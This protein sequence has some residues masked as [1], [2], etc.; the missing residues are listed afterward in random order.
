MPLGSRR[1]FMKNDPTMLPYGRHSLNEQDIAVV[2]DVLRGD[3]LTTGPTVAAFE[4]A[5]AAA[6]SAPHA[7]ACANGTAAL[8]L[9]ILGLDIGPG[10]TAIVPTMTFAATA[11]CVRLAGGEVVFA[12]VDPAT[13][14][15]RAEDLEDALARAGDARVRVV[16]PVHYAGQPVE[17]PTIASMARSRGLRIVE[18]AAHAVGTQYRDGSETAPVGACRHGDITTFSFHPV[19][20]ITMGEGGAI[21]TADAGLARRI[22]RLRGHGIE[23]DPARFVGI[24][25]AG[26]TPGPWV[27]EVQEVGLNYRASDLQCALGLSQLRRLDEFVARRGALVARYDERLAELAPIV[28]PIS[29]VEGAR[30]AWHLYPVHIDFE[31]LG[32][33][34]SAVMAALRAQRIHTQVLY[35]PVHRQPYYRRRYGTAALPGAEAFY[36]R[37]LALPLF[38]A[39]SDSDVD[40]VVA[41]IADIVGSAG[42]AGA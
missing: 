26:N 19:K 36:S 28:R 23:R 33:G 37:M 39:M 9:A 24:G 14:L 32:R 38:P 18:D 7:V 1:R 29:R 5:L 6:V 3:W 41:A 20:T 30:T 35:I 40:R 17:M 8:H 13:G 34:R 42:R 22:A 11:N 25:D 21:T 10:D 15:M 16:L 31:A 12:D 2:I 4:E 27:Y